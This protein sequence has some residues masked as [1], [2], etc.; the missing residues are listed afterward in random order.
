MLTGKYVMHDMVWK[1]PSQDRPAELTLSNETIA[2]MEATLYEVIKSSSEFAKLVFYLLIYFYIF[3]SGFTGG[4]LS[5]N[6]LICMNGQN[7]F[8]IN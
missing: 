3:G 5:I 7:C 1:L 8:S 4:F 6:F 2:A